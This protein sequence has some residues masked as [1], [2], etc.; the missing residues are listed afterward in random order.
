M[1]SMHYESANYLLALCDTFCNLLIFILG[2]WELH[3]DLHAIQSVQ[4]TGSL[5]IYV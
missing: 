5:T 4:Q 3:H 2:F 1:S